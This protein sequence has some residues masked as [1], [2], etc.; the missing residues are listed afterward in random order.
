[1]KKYRIGIDVG[2]TKTAYGLFDEENAFIDRLQEPTNPETDG[3]SLANRILEQ[4]DALLLR[5][6]IKQDD[7]EGV[8]ICMP[9]F[10]LYDEGYICMTSAMVKPALLLF[11]FMRFPSFHATKNQT[12]HNAPIVASIRDTAEKCKYKKKRA[13]GRSNRHDTSF[14]VIRNQG[15]VSQKDHIFSL[16]L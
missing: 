1:M 5:N 12:G 14:P 9:S 7:L 2:G 16:C 13:L 3:P 8:G 11:C 6:H 4:I 10:I 15:I